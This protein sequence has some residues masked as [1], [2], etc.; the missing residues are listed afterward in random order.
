LRSNP[1]LAVLSRE[2][3]LDEPPAGKSALKRLELVS[4]TGRDHKI[5]YSAEPPSRQLSSR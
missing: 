3:D 4:R 5:D 1:L 2:R